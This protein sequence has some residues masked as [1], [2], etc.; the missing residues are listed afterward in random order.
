MANELDELTGPVAT[1]GRD[2]HVIDKQIPVTVGVGS[3]VFEVFLW[4]LAII[5]GLI[6]QLMKTRALSYLQGLQQQIQGAAST[7]DNYQVKRVV[8]LQ[9][10]AK[11]LEK[12]VDLDKET[13]TKIAAYRSGT[14]ISDKGRIEL[15]GAADSA[16]NSINVALENYPELKS[17]STIRD[18]MQQ[19]ELLQQEITS[20]RELYNAKVLQ[21]N[22]EIF[23][24][25]TKKI[26]AAKQ[27]YTTRIPFTAS[28]E[29]KAKSEGV[30]F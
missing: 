23:Q 16:M 24:W 18:C 15:A 22:T 3:K 29:M 25:P 2:V 7:I 27:G 14:P 19:N 5:P 9:N 12:S 1:A 6:F 28:A 8:V 4:V 17:H 10:A 26:V 21:W 20:A 30:F 13:F 11:L